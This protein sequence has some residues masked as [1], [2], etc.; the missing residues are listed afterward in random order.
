MEK[1]FDKKNLGIP[2]TILS[3]LAYFIG[4]YLTLNFSGLLVA[5]VFA[6]LVFA[7]DFDD[8]VK[9]AVKQSYI[10]AL[11]FNLVYLGLAILSN[12]SDLITPSDYND[13]FF[14]QKAFFNIHKY[15]S[16]LFNI[17]VIVVFVLFII[18]VLIKKDMKLGFISNL[19]GEGTKQQ[20]PMP[21][22]GQPVPPMPQVGQPVPPM[23]Q[24]VQGTVCP[25]CNTVNRDGAA[26][27]ASCGQ[28]L[29]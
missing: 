16:I 3:L 11:F 10:F 23:N 20:K 4:Y 9:T 14:L 29:Q 5:V 18:C 24:Q 2:V 21:Q 27:C 13:E 17:A 28:K 6:V 12:L 22:V 26:F 7:L 19:S 1:L 8:K 15:A 25:K